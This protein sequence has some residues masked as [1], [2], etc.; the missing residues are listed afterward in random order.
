MKRLEAGVANALQTAY[1]SSAALGLRAVGAVARMLQQGELGGAAIVLVES[2]E[3]RLGTGKWVWFLW[4]F[5]VIFLIF[6]TF[7][8]VC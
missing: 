4:C 2:L 3:K 8:D 6:L 5:F 1:A 7:L